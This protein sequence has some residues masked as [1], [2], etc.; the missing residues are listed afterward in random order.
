MRYSLTILLMLGGAML[1]QTQKVHAQQ[2][3]DSDD[4]T[5][6]VQLD[7]MTFEP[8]PCI[9]ITKANLNSHYWQTML[10]KLKTRARSDL[11]S[12]TVFHVRQE[13]PTKQAPITASAGMVKSFMPNGYISGGGLY[14]KVDSGD[15]ILWEHSTIKDQ[16]QTIR[17]GHAASGVMEFHTTQPPAKGKPQCYDIYLKVCPKNMRG[18]LVM[19]LIKPKHVTCTSFTINMV[20]N[21]GIFGIDYRWPHNNNRAIEL[22]PGPYKFLFRQ[23]N[24]REGRF[25]FVIKPGVATNLAF[26]AQ[27]Q[28]TIE[29]I[30]QVFKPKPGAQRLLAGRSPKHIPQA[31]KPNVNTTPNPEAEAKKSDKTTDSSA[32]SKPEAC[33]AANTPSDQTTKPQA[34]EQNAGAN[35][36]AND[37]SQKSTKLDKEPSQQQPEIKNHV[38]TQHHQ[39]PI[40]MPDTD[41][42]ANTPSDQTKPQA[43]EQDAAANPK[44]NDES[45][46]SSKLDKE[47]SQQQP[48]IKNHVAI[49]HH[50]T[51][52]QMPNPD[53][54]GPLI[55]VVK[56]D[57]DSQEW[58]GGLIMP[59]NQ[60]IAQKMNY[61]I[62]RVSKAQGLDDTPVLFCAT[63]LKELTPE[64]DGGGGMYFK[65]QDGDFFIWEH[66]RSAPGKKDS[67][68]IGHPQAG[69]LDFK[70]TVPKAGVINVIGDVV[71]HAC[72]D[73]RYGKVQINLDK[74]DDIEASGFYIGTITAGGNLSTRYPLDA[75][76]QSK[77]IDL[78]PGQYKLLLGN[79]GRKAGLSN[80]TVEEGKTTE[81]KFKAI[82]QN[83][84]VKQ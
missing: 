56:A 76:G 39:T 48:E 45:Q 11:F 19:S 17:I 4:Q 79:F 66:I 57:I 5:Q 63:K 73:K 15:A 26:Q 35:P 54:D 31:S 61:S 53:Y 24:Q 2:T 29:L 33:E 60:K 6:L 18:K 7:H 58:Q 71:V 42:A 30:S 23:I 21:G 80:F 77:L 82:S 40:P 9:E 83:E 74:S 36:K 70:T 37:E 64:N 32:E 44:A 28:N 27:S 47:P 38:A 34:V 49:Q 69:G 55:E 50:Q 68:I 65:A 1:L 75:N 43:D 52:I 62:A 22:A 51:A 78:P 10:G 41:E 12:F 59:A 3:A 46:K 8:H 14:C 81:L 16:Q 67:L 20:A 72:P 84:L 13:Y 25:D